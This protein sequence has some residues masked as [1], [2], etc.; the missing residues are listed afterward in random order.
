[1]SAVDIDPEVAVALAVL[2]AEHVALTREHQRLEMGRDALASY[3]AHGLTLR[4]HHRRLSDFY[5]RLRRDRLA[6]L[7][8]GPA[9]AVSGVRSVTERRN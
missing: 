8:S 4:R 6:S 3:R 2:R 1:M 7:T 9:P 5:A